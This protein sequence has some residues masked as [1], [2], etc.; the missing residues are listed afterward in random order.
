MEP[1]STYL[2]ERKFV[3]EHLE[4]HRLLVLGSSVPSAFFLFLFPFLR[5]DI[6][7]NPRDDGQRIA[8]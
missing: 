6:Q 2:G 3:S 8:K 5:V 7:S 1:K 4:S